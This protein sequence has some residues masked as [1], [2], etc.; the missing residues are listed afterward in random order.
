[1][2]AGSSNEL[3]N[4]EVELVVVRHQRGFGSHRLASRSDT[5]SAKGVSRSARLAG[6]AYELVEGVG[7]TI[8]QPQRPRSD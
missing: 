6:R 3:L 2:T 7:R 4:T 1:V 8:M 5:S